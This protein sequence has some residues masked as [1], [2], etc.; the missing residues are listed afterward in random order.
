MSKVLNCDLRRE[1]DTTVLIRGERNGRADRRRS[2]R[3]AAA[4]T[5]IVPVNCGAV[6]VAWRANFLAWRAHRRAVLAQGKLEMADG[7]RSPDEVGRS[8]R[9]CR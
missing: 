9:R 6:G 7:G 4:A 5:L 8:A 3:T 2:T 1:T